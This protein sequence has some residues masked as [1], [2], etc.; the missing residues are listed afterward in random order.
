MP[1][2]KKE[3]K[4]SE[5]LFPEVSFN[6]SI[7]K[8]TV[9][10]FTYGDLIDLSKNLEAILT[11]FV[12]R[13]I[14]IDPDQMNITDF[15]SIYLFIG[16]P[17]LPILTRVTKLSEDQVRQLTIVECTQLMITIVQQNVEVFYRFFEK[18]SSGGGLMRMRQTPSLK[19]D[20]TEEQDK[21]SLETMDSEMSSQPSSGMDTTS[22][23]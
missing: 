5:V 12:T 16:E 7:G 23:T 14:T 22:M 10:P 8:V 1:R 18:S 13:E 15:L 11:E 4:D 19:P 21:K 17:A 6:F 2:I 9:T 3:K 20:E